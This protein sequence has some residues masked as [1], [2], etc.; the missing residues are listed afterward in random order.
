MIDLLLAH[1]SSLPHDVTIHEP[2]WKYIFNGACG[3]ATIIIA[4]VNIIY[5]YKF[6]HKQDESEKLAKEKDRKMMLLKTLVLDHNLKHLYSSF[7]MLSLH[8]QELRSDDNEA[9]RKAKEKDI[10]N[11][12]KALSEDFV[13]L[14]SAV[15]TK[16][17]QSILAESDNLRDT[18]VTNLADDGV[19]LTVEAKY[20]EFINNP[21][22][23]AKKNILSLLF[24]Y[25]G[26]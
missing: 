18:L 24:D 26:E 23:N 11:D 17:Y 9:M 16:L 7:D 22:M 14:L 19:K 5:I 21:I 1:V 2:L 25:K 13:F 10:Q 4:V 20:K 6:H 12:L 15:N 3:I 8:L